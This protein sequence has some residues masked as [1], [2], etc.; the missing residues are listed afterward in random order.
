MYP[1][2]AQK[3]GGVPLFGEASKKDKKR[4]SG[5]AP[6]SLPWWWYGR[7]T[8]RNKNKTQAVSD[9]EDKKITDGRR[10]SRDASTCLGDTQISVRLVPVQDSFGSLTRPIIDVAS[11]VIRFRVQKHIS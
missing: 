6:P 10:A 7:K 4:K 2:L 3:Q 8:K 11:E 1:F 5:G 9:K